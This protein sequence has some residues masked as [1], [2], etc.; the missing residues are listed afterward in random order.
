MV[1]GFLL[2]IDFFQCAMLIFFFFSAF[3]S[4][5][6]YECTVQENTA[7][8]MKR[9][10]KKKIYIDMYIYLLAMSSCLGTG[11][12]LKRFYGSFIPFFYYYATCFFF[13]FCEFT[14]INVFTPNSSR[15]KKLS[16]EQFLTNKY[17]E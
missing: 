13:R 11:L 2:L 6:I 7:L 5:K 14:K 1:F 17:G 9:S 16:A 10:K 8:K 12:E 15:I 4:L 3:R